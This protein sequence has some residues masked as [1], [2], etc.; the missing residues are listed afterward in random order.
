M[1]LFI[2][3]RNALLVGCTSALTVFGQTPA[4]AT[5]T[6]TGQI[7]ERIS[8]QPVAQA[9]IIIAGHTEVTTDPE[10]R[11][12]IELPPGHY[13]GRI[14]AQG[15][16]PLMT[17]VI[18]VTAKYVSNYDARLTVQV[19]EEITVSSGYFTQTTDQPISNVSLR[20]AEIRAV[21]GTGGDVLRVISS[22]P[23][24]TTDSLQF[25]DLLVRGGMPGENLTFIDNIP[26]GDF[27]YFTDQYDNGRG[28]RAAVLAPDLFERLEFSAG[29]FG[30]RYGDRMSS[31]LDVT[32]RRA[33]RDRVQGSV[34]ADSG[35]AGFSA[36]VPLAQRGGW[37]VSLRRSYIDLA[38]ELFDLGDIGKPRNLDVV[39][40]FDFD[41]AP[42]HR[43]SLTAMNFSERITI[44]LETARRASRRDQLITERTSDRFILGATLS[45][46]LGERTLSQL[47]AW[48]WSEHNDGSFLRL[49]QRTLQRQRDLRETQFGMKE[50]LTTAIAPRLNLSAGGGL[51]VQQGDYFTFELSPVG[52]SPIGEEYRA[53]TRSNLLRIDPTVSVYA[54]AQLAW[55][56][57]SRLS[58]SPGVRVDRYGI[59]QQ[60][61]VSPRVSARFRMASRFA[62]NFA[63]GIYR[64]PPASFILALT[65]ANRSLQAQQ[66]IHAIAGF[67]WQVREDTRVNVEAYQKNYDDLL[68]QPTRSLPQFFNS[69]TSQVRGIEV[70]AQKAL[71]GRFAGQAAY[72]YTFAR[73]KLTA[74]GTSFP[75]EVTRPHQLTLIGITQ[76][77]FF[78]RWSLAARLRAA[79]GLAYSRLTPVTYTTPVRVTLFELLNPADRH[80]LRLPNFRQLDLRAERRFDFNRWSFS[81]Y[82]DLFNLTKRVNIVDVNYRFGSSTPGFWRE[83]T[84]IPIVGARIEF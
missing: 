35:T 67:A 72:A 43:L 19:A 58:I 46:T 79:S 61:L 1:P 49:D 53:P 51:S 77:K 18:T 68:I 16:A 73:R 11:Y 36:E 25:A 26:V 76:V 38:F 10:G 50:E 17:G 84:L 66:A 60:T 32:L 7:T 55:Q 15:Y 9:R 29:G 22:L 74:D 28:G 13:H 27:T 69:G 14:E 48:G 6:I 2:S 30:T 62:L 33:T 64:Q 54:Y 31:A 82:V 59:T 83:K 20:R 52:Y 34:F 56:A 78:G 63:T 41:L 47:T 21:P 39:N 40:K 44:P 42:R 57:T 81:P 5:G 12:R 23:G 75:S 8:G 24:V 65:P 37:F 71:S 70:T 3:L 4:P 80:A 45:S